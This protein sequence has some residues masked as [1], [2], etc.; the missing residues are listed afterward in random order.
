[1]SNPPA[2]A[3]DDRLSLL[4][5][6]SQTFNSTLDLDEVLEC[7]MD[8]VIAVTRAE[9]GFVMLIEADGDLVFRTARGMDQDTVGDPDFQVS[10]GIVY[11]VARE[12]KPMLTSDA[13]S[14]S[15]LSLRASVIH[16]GLRSVL[17]V[18][19]QVK[20]NTIGVIY[21]DNRLQAGIF[22]HDDLELLNAIASTAAIAIENARLYQVAVEK[23][24]ME[25]ELQM[26]Y[27]IQA[28]LLPRSMP[29]LPGWEFAAR[30]KPA[31]EVAGDFYD[32]IPLEDGKLGLVIA[33]VTD[34]GMPAA[35]F[36]AFTRSIIR[37]S[38]DRTVQP[39]EAIRQAN[40]L[41]C[42]ESSYGFFV[43]LFYAQFEPDSA[44]VT[45]VSAGHSPQLRYLDTSARSLET[46]AAPIF[47]LGYTGMPLG[48]EEET[49]YEQRHL[50]CAPGDCLLLY[51]DGVTD[52]VNDRGEH[53]SLA[54]LQGF[55]QNNY[56]TS[57][58]EMVTN[59]ERELA[60]FVGDSPQFDDI[61]IVVAK[62]K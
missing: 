31:R 48:I 47:Q 51:T 50:T 10:R 5:R 44:E 22:T 27:R 40:R 62:R 33:D 16:L 6:L 54:R 3:S 59:L 46:A 61:T 42:R 49:P 26:A 21:V 20:G 60:N 12:G 29:E 39:V 24:R 41:I 11:Q 28:G 34:K 18:P 14:D 57:P 35:L 19:L 43:T 30:W 13:Q 56:R 53:F 7:V 9:R 17:C 36:M 37:A 25:R 32:F 23:G 8:E 55:G 52:A 4:Y 45:Y 38:L 2:P 1:M 58:Q 15:Q